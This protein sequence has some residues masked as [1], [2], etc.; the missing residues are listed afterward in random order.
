MFWKRATV[1]LFLAVVTLFSWSQ[2]ITGDIRGVVR[3]PSGAVV[4]GASVQVINTD[5]GSVIRALTTGA[6]GNY[7]AS[8][9]P[10]GRYKVAVEASGFKKYEANDIVINVNDR[11]VVNIDLQLGATSQSVTVTEAAAPIDLETP[12]ASGLLT[13]DQIRELGTVTRNYEQLVSLVPGVSTNL[14]SD[15][16]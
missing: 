16:L 6:D 4:R 1:A 5:R 9:L 10:V 8:L 11:R 2:E 14:A 12:A 7:V 13:G 3:D 15:Q